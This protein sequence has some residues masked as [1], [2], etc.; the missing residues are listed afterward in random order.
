MKFARDTSVKLA[1]EIKT[2][3]KRATTEED[4]RVNV[5]Q[6]LKPVLTKLGIAVQP[7]YEQRLTLLRGSGRAD[8]VYG[9][10]VIEYER[11][12]RLATPAGRKEV[13]RQLSAYLASKARELAPSR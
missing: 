7:K 1:K 8:A 4:V 12:G 6:A 3:G 11:P 5:E 13:V 10:G 9:F 2:I